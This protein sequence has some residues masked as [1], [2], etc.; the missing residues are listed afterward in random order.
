M[1][2]Q[3]ADFMAILESA[4]MYPE[5]IPPEVVIENSTLANKEVIVSKIEDSG[6][7]LKVKS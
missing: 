7:A 5:Q 4:R 1:I 6:E 3:Y 2:A